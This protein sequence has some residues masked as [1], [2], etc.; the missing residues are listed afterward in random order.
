[1]YIKYGQKNSGKILNKYEKR[2]ECLA[3]NAETPR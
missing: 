2:C 3:K 1:M